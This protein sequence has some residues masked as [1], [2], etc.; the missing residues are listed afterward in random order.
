MGSK[1]FNALIIQLRHARA[2]QTRDATLRTQVTAHGVSLAEM[3]AQ[4]D[5][6][7][8]A[9]DRAAEEAEAENER[10]RGELRE[11]RGRE[12]ALKGA[13]ALLRPGGEAIA[14]E[15]TQ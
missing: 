10:L 2:E 4:M 9:S 13:L 7:I 1:S 15:G 3:R 14:A 5:A 11:A 6:A 12:E 8:A